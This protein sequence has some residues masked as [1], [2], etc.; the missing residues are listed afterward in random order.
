MY[1]TDAFAPARAPRSP[2]AAPLVVD[3]PTPLLIAAD[4]ALLATNDPA[5][6]RAVLGELAEALADARHLEGAGPFARAAE[7]C[8]RFVGEA[9]WQYGFC[10][11]DIAGDLDGA[12]PSL[13]LTDKGSA[14]LREV[15][16]AA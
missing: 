11:D 5:A 10:A 15:A 12:P 8:A 9:G 14:A 13:A 4:L 7:R 2:L 6:F 1:R 3:R 16:A